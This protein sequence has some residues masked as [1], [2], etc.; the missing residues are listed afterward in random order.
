MVWVNSRRAHASR[1]HNTG[2]WAG[3]SGLLPA[4][5]P[6]PRA[7]SN[8]VTSRGALTAAGCPAGALRATGA[9]AA[10]SAGDAAGNA[11]VNDIVVTAGLVSVVT[12]SPTVSTA[13]FATA[14]VS[15]TAAAAGFDTDG[16]DVGFGSAL[17][18]FD[19]GLT[20]RDVGRRA[21]VR[22]LG[23]RSAG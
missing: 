6:N 1:P 20:G 5:G 16:A 3:A 21:S 7:A 13:F 15:V 19:V 22:A 9:G 17:V 10:D 8:P 18:F 23:A 12:A 2:G 4:S 14:A 11:T